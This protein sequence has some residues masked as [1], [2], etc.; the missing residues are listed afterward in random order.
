M[1]IGDF[2]RQK[3]FTD[4]VTGQQVPESRV[5]RIESIREIACSGM[6]NYRRVRASNYHLDFEPY[7]YIEAAER[8][9][10]PA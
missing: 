3:A 10:I 6:P 2:V 7:R 8:F 1:K 4:S 9:F 5:L